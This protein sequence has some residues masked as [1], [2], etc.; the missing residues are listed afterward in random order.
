M[1]GQTSDTL[2]NICPTE[3]TIY[4]VEITY[5]AG[6]SS[7]TKPEDQTTHAIICH[8]SSITEHTNDQLNLYP[9]PS[10]KNITIDIDHSLMGAEFEIVDVF[11]KRVFKSHF[12]NLSNSVTISEY[13]DGIYFLKV[14]GTNILTR[15]VKG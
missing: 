9:N 15:F 12:N 7:F 14:Q 11:G 13:S 10:R 4:S 3:N 5:S 8:P 6:C 2:L 1:V